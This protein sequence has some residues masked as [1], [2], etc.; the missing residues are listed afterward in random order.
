MMGKIEKKHSQTKSTQHTTT[1]PPHNST[2]RRQAPDT[3][4]H[5]TEQKPARNPNP[6]NSEGIYSSR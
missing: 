6:K 5:P 2:P 1:Q 3:P 4:D